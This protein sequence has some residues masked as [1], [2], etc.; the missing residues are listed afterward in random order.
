M[1]SEVNFPS[2][3]E[4]VC[5]LSQ[6]LCFVL[7]GAVET[8]LRGQWKWSWSTEAVCTFLNAGHKIVGFIFDNLPRTTQNL[9][10]AYFL[11]HFF[12]WKV[13]VIVVRLHECSNSFFPL[14][15]FSDQVFKMSWHVVFGDFACGGP[16]EYILYQLNPFPFP[17]FISAQ[18][19]GRFIGCS[20]TVD[21]FSKFLPRFSNIVNKQNWR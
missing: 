10:S 13:L 2:K 15:T 16:S 11:L 4:F 5:K 1:A 8:V 19:T 18:R 21:A 17:A 9:S 20:M 14:W 7:S 3:E 6:A 12:I